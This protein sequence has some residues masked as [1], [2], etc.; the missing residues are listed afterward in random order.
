MRTL[1]PITRTSLSTPLLEEFDKFFND[2]SNSFGNTIKTQQGKTQS[3]RINAYKKD[4]K[5]FIDAA[6]P[7]A[8]KDDIDIEIEENLLKI[9]VNAHQDKEVSDNDYII[10]EVS[11]SQMT[12]IL[13]L[14]EDVDVESAKSNFKDGVLHIEFNAKKIEEENRVKKIA[15]E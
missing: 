3:P 1:F 13:T 2:F 4:G 10:R 8:T 6:V 5:Y 11:R 14:G 12:R 15:I 7:F 9:T